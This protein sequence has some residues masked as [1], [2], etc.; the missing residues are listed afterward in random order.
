[1]A[2]RIRLG[3]QFQDDSDQVI[4]L[5]RTHSD[6]RK[7]RITSFASQEEMIK[8][9]SATD[10]RTGE[11]LYEKSPLFR[12]SIEEIVANTEASTIGVQL[13]RPSPIPDDAT[14]MQGLYED[15]LRAQHA[16]L[17]DRAGGNDLMAKYQLA[18]MLL[19]PTEQQHEN[20]TAMQQLTQPEGLR[21]HE[22]YLKQRKANGLGPWQETVQIADDN[23]AYEQQKI[24][25]ALDYLASQDIDGSTSIGEQGVNV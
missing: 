4:P 23:S 16:Q 20:F 1:M 6:G 14:F 13:E 12:K 9:M 5:F 25:E 15:A 18:Q 19:N 3:R 7:E 10:P 17:V 24:D 2:D 22:E 21:P 11:P 8:A